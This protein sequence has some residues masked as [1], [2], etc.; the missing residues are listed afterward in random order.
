M[1]ENPETWGEF[2]REIARSPALLSRFL[3]LTICIG[4]PIFFL[5]R[6]VT[7]IIF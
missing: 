3:F 4:T 2:M 6:A 7:G 5:I 1:S